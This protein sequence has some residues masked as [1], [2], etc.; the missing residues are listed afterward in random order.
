[1]GSSEMVDSG[2][3]SGGRSNFSQTCSLLSRYLKEKGSFGGISLGFDRKLDSEGAPTETMNL[4]PMIEKS[5]RNSSTTPAGDEALKNSDLSGA[6]SA[7][8]TAPM[9]IFYGGKVIVFNDF[10]ADKAKELMILAQKSSTAHNPNAALAP[11]PAVPSPAES[12]SSIVPLPSAPPPPPPPLDSDLPI[13][14]KNSLARFLEKRKDRVTANVPYPAN[15][16][17]APPKPVKTEP[18]L[19]LSPNLPLQIQPH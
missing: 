13:A 1:M 12:V 7:A 6:K 18:W 16:P 14:R 5:G 8:E 17:A 19:G 3:I 2:R 15:K 11:P 4:L 9:T 10:P